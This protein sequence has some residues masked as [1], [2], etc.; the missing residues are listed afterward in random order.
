MPSLRAT[1]ISQGRLL[2]RQSIPIHLDERR[3]TRC[4][5][6]SF[7]FWGESVFS[8]PGKA[9]GLASLGY[10]TKHHSVPQPTGRV[11]TVFPAWQVLPE[12]SHRGL[13]PRRRGTHSQAVPSIG[14]KLDTALSHMVTAKHRA[15]RRTERLILPSAGAGTVAAGPPQVR[16]G[17]SGSF[18][19]LH[20]PLGFVSNFLASWPILRSTGTFSRQDYSAYLNCYDASNNLRFY[21]QMYGFYIYR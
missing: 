17:K 9:L 3:A 19:M 14:L 13:I 4:Q 10:Q 7:S 15:G 21:L 16:T 11:G 2:S 5:L 8:S 6:C 20:H 18:S 1:V 12:G